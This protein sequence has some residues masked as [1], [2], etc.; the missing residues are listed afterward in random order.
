MGTQHIIE[1]NGKRYDTLTGRIVTDTVPKPSAIAKHLKHKTVSMDGFSKR[2]R[3][4]SVGAKTAHQPQKSKT[5][6]RQHVQKPAHPKAVHTPHAPHIMHLT[7]DVTPS[8]LAR[9]HATHQS[10]LIQH[11]GRRG[12][13]S[14]PIAATADSSQSL[15]T[16]KPLR[17]ADRALAEATA[18]TQPRVKRPRMHQRVAKRLRIKPHTLNIMAGVFAALVLGSF[19][20]YQ[21]IPNFAMRVAAARSGVH[22]TLPTYHPA[23]FSLHGGISYR[24]GEITIGYKSNSDKRNFTVTQTASSWDSETL[25]DNYV[26]VKHP[27]YQTV[28]N[29]GK[30]VYIYDN[31]NATWVDGGIWYRVEGSSDL[32]S[33][34]LLHLAGS[35]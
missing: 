32:N 7:T 29:D 23:G 2:P 17:P 3:P 26:A 19:I 8:R 28:Q 14:A 31:S 9:A 21:N 34:Q 10:K 11:F 6:M 18:H 15:V 4:A 35:M 25:L 13:E 33:D 22:G 20:A 12:V 24:A 27:A 30:T 1:L 16:T 5:L